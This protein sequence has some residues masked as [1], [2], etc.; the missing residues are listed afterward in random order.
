MLKPKAQPKPKPKQK[1]SDVPLGADIEAGDIRR[2]PPSLRAVVAA[3]G[4]ARACQFLDKFGGTRRSIDHGQI[5][6]FLR[7][8]EY[9]R[10]CD[11]FG[12]FLDY[13]RK[14]I[15]PKTDKLIQILRNY[16][17]VRDR[18]A[19]ASLSQLARKY[20]L[21]SR[22]V[23][24]ICQNPDLADRD[25]GILPDYPDKTIYRELSLPLFR[26]LKGD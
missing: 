5:R 12:Q 18:M 26:S 20:R 15:L 19:G 21:T 3:L 10:L 7:Q 14:I 8:D 9:Q 25:A 23:I 1:H 13:E 22:H 6:Q 24:N 4:I 2:L 17:L 11:N 16:A